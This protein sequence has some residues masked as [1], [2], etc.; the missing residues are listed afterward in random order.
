MINRYDFMKAQE[1]EDGTI[2][3]D[4]L[5]LPLDKFLSTETAQQLIVKQE[6]YY[7]P[8]LMFSE[9][10]GN[11]NM[12]DI[13]LWLNM[14]PSRRSMTPSTVLSVP[15]NRDLNTFYIKNRE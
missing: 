3:P 5:S 15:S 14:I 7:R 13:I 4:C 1:Q 12:E 9:L 6:H 10:L 8:D 11:N 2:Y